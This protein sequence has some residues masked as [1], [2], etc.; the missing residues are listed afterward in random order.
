MCSVHSPHCRPTS[1]VPPHHQKLLPSS[2]HLQLP[3]C[4]T[5]AHLCFQVA[6]EQSPTTL[7]CLCSTI[8][9]S[10]AMPNRTFSGA[11]HLLSIVKVDLQHNPILWLRQQCIEIFSLMLH[12]CRDTPS[13]NRCIG[14]FKTFKSVDWQATGSPTA[15]EPTLEHLVV[16]APGY[17]H[18]TTAM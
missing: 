11:T 1:P 5:R 18:T 8:Q 6:Q 13:S 7:W 4:P 15:L 10:G 2:S 17:P 14:I 16:C 9:T 3:C 12:G